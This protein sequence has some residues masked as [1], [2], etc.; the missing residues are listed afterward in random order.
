MKVFYNY[1]SD[2]GEQ[3]IILR[4]EH[5]HESDEDTVSRTGHEAV[6]VKKVI[7]VDQC[8]ITFSPAACMTDDVTKQVLFK[9][10]YYL[11]I[12]DYRQKNELISRGMY[13]WDDAVALGKMFQSCSFEKASLIWK[14]KQL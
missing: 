14:M 10:M 7:P 11:I 2:N 3:W 9:D 6:M 4:E 12:T 1:R 5:D 13:T 8:S